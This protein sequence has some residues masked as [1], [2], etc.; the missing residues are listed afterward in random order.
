MNLLR[1]A[2]EHSQPIQAFALGYEITD[3]GGFPLK[4]PHHLGSSLPRARGNLAIELPLLEP[5]QL[6]VVHLVIVAVRVDQHAL[7]LPARPLLEDPD[8]G[9]D[10]GAERDQQVDRPHLLGE[11]VALQQSASTALALAAEEVVTAEAAMQPC[12]SDMILH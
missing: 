12:L 10:A 9:R 7:P 1:S 8:K 6:A 4:Q 5:E 11:E 2:V 3:S